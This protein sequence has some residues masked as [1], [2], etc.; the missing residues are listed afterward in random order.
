MICHMDDG[1]WETRKDQVAAMR[2]LASTNG[3]CKDDT[4]PLGGDFLAYLE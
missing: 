3:T 2:D 4:L 1:E